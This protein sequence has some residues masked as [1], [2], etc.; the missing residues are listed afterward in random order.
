MLAIVGLALIGISGVR[1]LAFCRPRTICPYWTWAKISPY[2]IPVTMNRDC[3][4]GDNPKRTE[5][6]FSPMRRRSARIRWCYPANACKRQSGLDGS[7]PDRKTPYRFTAWF[8]AVGKREKIVGTIVTRCVS[9]ES[10]VIELVLAVGRDGRVRGARLQRL[11]EPE[12]RSPRTAIQ[13][14]LKRVQRQNLAVKLESSLAKFADFRSRKALR[15]FPAGRR[16]NRLGSAARRRTNVEKID[17]VGVQVFRCSGV[18]D[19]TTVHICCCAT[20][21]TVWFP[22][23]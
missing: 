3:V 7:R 5:S 14:F 8:G 16:A 12:S 15:R 19:N 6:G 1:E 10:G 22:N 20:R 11:R 2:A 4:P 9:G 23:T 17:I 21:L 18:Q 13:S